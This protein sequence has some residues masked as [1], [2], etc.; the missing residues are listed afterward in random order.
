MGPQLYRCGNWSARRRPA[1]GSDRFIGAATLS[2]RK[3]GWMAQLFALITGFNGAATLSLRKHLL[4]CRVYL[5][6]GAASMGPQLYRCGSSFSFR[7]LISVIRQLQWGRNFIVAET[8]SVWVSMRP[9]ASASMGPQLYRCGNRPTTGA[10]TP[11]APRFNGAATLSLRKP[12]NR[13]RLRRPK[14]RFNGAAT[15]SLRKPIWSPAVRVM[16]AALQWGRNFIVA[17]TRSLRMTTGSYSGFN[18]AATLSLRKLTSFLIG[19]YGL[20]VLQWGRNFIV[21]ETRFRHPVLARQPE[22]QWGRN[23]IVAE[24]VPSACGRWPG[25]TCFNGAATLSLRKLVARGRQILLQAGAS[26]GPQFYRCGNVSP[27]LVDEIA[28]PASM[29]PQ[30]YRCGN[31]IAKYPHTYIANLLQWGRNF[32]VAET[33]GLA[34]LGDG[35]PLASMGPQLY[36]CGNMSSGVPTSR[37]TLCFNGAATLSLRKPRAYP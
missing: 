28:V 25:Q 15:L 32:I 20:D 33:E 5:A 11:T 19:S 37:H 18:G 4:L 22:L 30:L 8:I 29:G 24:T 14:N 31:E 36:R 6:L 7:M 27:G 2:L 3:L 23:F 9:S 10:G 12:E 21:A 35:V 1:R 17:E 16:L 26:M 34:P 13:V